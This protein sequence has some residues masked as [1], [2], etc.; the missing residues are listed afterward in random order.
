MYAVGSPVSH[1]TSSSVWLYAYVP[2][3]GCPWVHSAAKRPGARPAAFQGERGGTR[4]AAVN[5]FASAA[6]R[7]RQDRHSQRLPDL[8]QTPSEL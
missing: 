3:R 2:R 8:V 4:S 6:P 7:L 5:K 1:S